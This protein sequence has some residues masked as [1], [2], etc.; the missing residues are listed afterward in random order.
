MR[1]EIDL[2][3]VRTREAFHDRIV[4]A[5]PCPA[6]YGRNLDALYDILT[7]QNGQNEKNEETGI[8]ELIFYN[9]TDLL[10]HMPDYGAALKALCAE[11][12]EQCPGLRIRFAED[13]D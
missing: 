1:Y 7:E 4:Q 12:M 6:F 9:M 10:R 3:N 13:A 8:E 2:Q 5:L 11:A